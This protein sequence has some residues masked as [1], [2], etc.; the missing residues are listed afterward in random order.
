MGMSIDRLLYLQAKGIL[1]SDSKLLDIGPQNVF[2]IPDDKLRDFYSRAGSILKGEAFE[3]EI[4][5]IVYFST[6]RPDERTTLLSEII[7]LTSV[8]YNS[9]DVCPGLKTDIVDLNY[10]SLRSRYKEYYDIVLNFGTTEH[11]FNQWNS[12]RIMHD[13]L[14]TGGIL[15]CQLPATGYLDHGYYC[16]TPL[17]FHDLAEANDYVIVDLFFTVAGETHLDKMGIDFR[18]DD[19]MIPCQATPSPDRSVFSNFNVHAVLRKT[20]SAPFRLRLE[21]ATAHAGVDGEIL[22]R[23]RG[24]DGKLDPL[25]CVAEDVRRVRAELEVARADLRHTQDDLRHTQDDLRRTQDEAAVAR[26]VYER[27]ISRRLGA[28]FRSIVR[29]LRGK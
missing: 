10:E 7:A 23:Y 18:N 12:F 14:K 19:G 13:A 29:A 27:T 6:P 8:E 11:V 5:R 4:Q 1:K 15:Y 25:G 3:K 2:C 9:F 24:V 16:Y 22:E 26:G 21:V 20:R 28:P 17:F